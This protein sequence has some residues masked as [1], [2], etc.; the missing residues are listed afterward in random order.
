MNI[1]PSSTAAT[2]SPAGIQVT[3]DDSLDTSRVR[4]PDGRSATKNQVR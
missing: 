3:F 2:A 4:C 1:R